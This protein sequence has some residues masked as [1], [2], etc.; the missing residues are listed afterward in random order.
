MQGPE[1]AAPDF[2]EFLHTVRARDR[3]T[4]RALGITLPSSILAGATEILD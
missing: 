3:K 4:A 2:R 1:P